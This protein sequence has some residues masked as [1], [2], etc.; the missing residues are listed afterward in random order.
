MRDQFY[1]NNYEFHYATEIG[2]ITLL[3][4]LLL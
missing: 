2:L 1:V 3:G 4:L